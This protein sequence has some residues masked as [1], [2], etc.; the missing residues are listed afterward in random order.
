MV[1]LG[2]QLHF[3]DGVDPARAS[4][5]DHW[6][7]DLTNASA[8]WQT[9]TPLPFSR[10]HM[11]GVVLNGKIYAIGGQPGTDDSNPSRDVLVWDPADPSHWTAAASLPDARSHATATVIDGR[12]VLFG[13]TVVNDAPIASVIAYDPATNSW[14]SLNDLP[15]P[16]LAPSGGLVGNQIIITGGYDR[17]LRTETWLADVTVA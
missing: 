1:L 16:R 15:G 14:S 10:N 12:I 8:T 3:F 2:N 13:G 7:L 4:H 5:T 6:T 17:G 9:S 11:D